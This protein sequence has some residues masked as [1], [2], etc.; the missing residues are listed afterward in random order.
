MEENIRRYNDNLFL[1]GKG[2]FNDISEKS[3][4]RG[5]IWRNLTVSHQYWGKASLHLWRSSFL[6]EM[7]QSSQEYSQATSLRRRIEVPNEGNSFRGRSL[8]AVP[9]GRGAFGIVY[10]FVVAVMGKD[11][12]VLDV[13]VLEET[14]G[15]VFSGFVKGS[16]GPVRVG[17]VLDR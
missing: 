12:L 3:S 13:D 9:G 6:R 1:W 16:S 17:Q 5:T 8:A 4:I 7:V 14:Y 10:R 15:V 2:D 11:D